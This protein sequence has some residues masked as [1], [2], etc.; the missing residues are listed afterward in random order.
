MVVL[1]Y[2]GNGVFGIG[3]FIC[4]DY[5]VYFWCDESK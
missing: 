3:I 2:F 4:V 5:F 1:V